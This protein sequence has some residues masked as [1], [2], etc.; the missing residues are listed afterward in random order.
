MPGSG[1]ARPPDWRGESA[2]RPAVA[3]KRCTR[4]HY[5]YIPYTPF[6][7]SMVTADEQQLT[8]NGMIDHDVVTLVHP[9]ME[10]LKTSRV[11]LAKHAPKL[12][13]GGRFIAEPPKGLVTLHVVIDVCCTLESLFAYL[14]LC[15]RLTGRGA[16]TLS[17]QMAI[18]LGTKAMPII[19][20]YSSSSLLDAIRQA[21]LRHPTEILAEL[22]THG[23]LSS[24]ARY[25][26]PFAEFD[27]V[28]ARRT[29]VWISDVVVRRS[30]G[31]E[32]VRRVVHDDKPTR[33]AS[34]RACSLLVL[35]AMVR[36]DEVRANIYQ[37]GERKVEV[38]HCTSHAADPGTAVAGEA[39]TFTKRW[40]V[41]AGL[42]AEDASSNAYSPRKGEGGLNRRDLTE[43]IL[44]E[45]RGLDSSSVMALNDLPKALA[46]PCVGLIELHPEEQE[47]YER[48]LG[49]AAELH[50][51]GQRDKEARLMAALEHLRR[52]SSEIVQQPLAATQ[53]TPRARARSLAH[54]VTISPTRGAERSSSPRRSLSCSRHSIHCAGAAQDDNGP[55][56]RA[57]IQPPRAS[58]SAADRA[59]HRSIV[60]VRRP[61]NVSP[62]LRDLGR[63][64]CTCSCAGIA[65]APAAA[66]VATSAPT[67]F[68]SDSHPLRLPLAVD[69]WAPS[70]IE[71]SPIETSQIETKLRD[72]S[73]LPGHH[74]ARNLSPRGVRPPPPTACRPFTASTRH[75]Q[76]EHSQ[77]NRVASGTAATELETVKAATEAATKAVTEAAIKAVTEAAISRV[78]TGAATEMTLR[79]G[80]AIETGRE[81][82]V[83]PPC[84]PK[85]A[86]SASSPT[87]HHLNTT[88][89]AKS[90]KATASDAK[91]PARITRASIDAPAA[92]Q[93][94]TRPEMNEAVM[95][96]EASVAACDPAV[97][98]VY[99]R[100]IAKMLGHHSMRNV[101][102]E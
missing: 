92:A 30:T 96:L 52:Q 68:V 36:Q 80:A 31:E 29:G 7:Y 25:C 37:V 45:Q 59:A 98:A 76:P 75:R 86:H 57:E 91:T 83:R 16:N 54:T 81:C 89:A 44:G 53:P 63:M 23:I 90:R 38:E 84:C 78:A 99:V 101:R 26:E 82:A 34:E 77:S 87:P 17:S 6:A 95:S 33:E 40:D 71:T 74:A 42:V 8:P 20:Q 72:R 88:P 56:K 100:L 66:A 5:N 21:V 93:D 50:R 22:F 51:S 46:T 48:L 10:N 49:R 94:S 67:H 2:K 55:P 39:M 28:M 58:C 60:A 41:L 32:I 15:E 3:P 70:Q 97:Q 73:E 24:P 102:L 14:E 27:K 11:P 12:L 13:A 62:R 61:Q 85:W 79:T 69:K 18:Q 43:A 47:E 19:L 1:V 64:A 9:F 4:I 65:A 35:H